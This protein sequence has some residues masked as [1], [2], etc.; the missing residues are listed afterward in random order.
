MN[1]NGNK[2]FS[3]VANY[4]EWGIINSNKAYP[5]S[6]NDQENGETKRLNS[7]ANY[8]V[9]KLYKERTNNDSK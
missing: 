5:F 9:K 1:C 7:K 8:L 3:V 6:K 4:A 2:Y